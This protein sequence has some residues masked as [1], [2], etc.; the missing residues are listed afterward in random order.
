MTDGSGGAA[1]VAVMD[2]GG[3]ADEDVERLAGNRLPLDQTP[4][5]FTG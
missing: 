3:C 1:T 4:G 5:H 2:S